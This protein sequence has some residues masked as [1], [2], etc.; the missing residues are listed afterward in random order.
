VAI[1]N[2]RRMKM[3]DI[4][5]AVAVITGAGSGI[6]EVV[7]KYWVRRGGKAVLA[8]II[9]ENLSQ[10]ERELKD[11]GGEVCSLLCDVTKEEDNARLPL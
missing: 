5:Q 4:E 8:D 7:A 2:K 9:P 10:V 3:L 11:L 6:G 1:Y